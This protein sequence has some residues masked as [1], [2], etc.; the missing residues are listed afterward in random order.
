MAAFTM[1]TNTEVDASG[2]NRIEFDP[3]A[4]TYDHLYITA[5]LRTNT[6]GAHQWDDVHLQFNDDTAST[7]SYTD[8]ECSSVS[9]VGGAQASGLRVGRATNADADADFFNPLEIWIPNYAGTDGTKPVIAKSTVVGDASSVTYWRM[10]VT[11]GVWRS[12]AAITAV[13]LHLASGTDLFVQ[14]SIATLYGVTGAV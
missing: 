9:P 2:I 7:S 5:S 10:H 11:S 3:I 12:T 14:Y 4:G 8:I 13:D 1:I 6:T